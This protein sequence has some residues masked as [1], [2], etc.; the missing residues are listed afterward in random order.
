[1]A[2]I[3]VWAKPDNDHPDIL[4]DARK[5][6]RGMVVDI[7][8]DGQEAGADIEAGGWW[9]IIEAPGPVSLYEDLLGADPEFNDEKLFPTLN[10]MPRKRVQAVDL[11]AVEDAAGLRG[12]S[13][14][15]PIRVTRAALVAQQKILA[16]RDNP[17]VIG[18]SEA[19]KVI[20]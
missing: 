5:F 2:R 8:A 3:V 15:L 17:T 13:P 7:L 14:E 10:P 4:I 19:I 12:K 18:P 11:D 1:M 9:R 6:K 20:G 16:K